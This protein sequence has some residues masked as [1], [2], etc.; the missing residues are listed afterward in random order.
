MG[1]IAPV[2]QGSRTS[3]TLVQVNCMEE[4]DR[5]EALTPV[6]RREITTPWR[7]RRRGSVVEWL[8]ANHGVHP[9]DIVN[10]KCDGG[11]D[12]DLCWYDAVRE[13]AELL[14]AVANPMTQ[15]AV[16]LTR[17]YAE[18]LE[19]QGLRTGRRLTT[20]RWMRCRGS[21]CNIVATTTLTSGVRCP[22]PSAGRTAR[23]R[24]S[25]AESS[26]PRRI[27]WACCRQTSEGEVRW[28]NVVGGQLELPTHVSS[29]STSRPSL[30]VDALPRT[31]LSASLGW[32]VRPFE[33]IRQFLRQL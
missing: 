15:C 19:Q 11:W 1:V 30:S 33:R 24:W 31:L 5:G 2:P 10:E 4:A 17:E 9:D 14:H 21:P 20:F 23:K 12:D 32:G 27:V 22:R 25:V 16:E 7:R 29:G 6:L 18:H 3:P 28:Q 13:L 26:R 8:Y